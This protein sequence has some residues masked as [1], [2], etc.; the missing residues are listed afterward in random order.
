MVL[1]ITKKQQEEKERRAKN[2]SESKQVRKEIAKTAKNL[3]KQKY[4]ALRIK[5]DE[6]RT[7]RLSEIKV[8]QQA[9]KDRAKSGKILGYLKK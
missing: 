3:A 4:R 8:H 9:N 6:K 7:R 1:K 2:E 5:N